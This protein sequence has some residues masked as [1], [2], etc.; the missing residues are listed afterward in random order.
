MAPVLFREQFL[1]SRNTASEIYVKTIGREVYGDSS[2][3]YLRDL[4][5]GGEGW[6]QASHRQKG[7]QITGEEHSH[8]EATQHQASPHHLRVHTRDWRILYTLPE[9][10]LTYM[11]LSAWSY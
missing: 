10:T 9:K 2:V 3:W 4:F 11:T 5:D 8:H 6:V 1:S 7:C